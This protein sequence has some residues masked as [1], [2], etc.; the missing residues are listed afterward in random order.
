MKAQ[1]KINEKIKEV[2]DRLN[3]KPVLK[4]TNFQLSELIIP[5]GRKHV[6]KRIGVS[7][8]TL[9]VKDKT[10]K[11]EKHRHLYR[12]HKKVD[13]GMGEATIQDKI[14]DFE[15]SEVKEENSSGNEESSFPTEDTNAEN[16]K[17]EEATTEEHV[18]EE[19]TTEDDI[20]TI[21]ATDPTILEK[22]TTEE[23]TEVTIIDNESFQEEDY[24][25][26][27]NYYITSQED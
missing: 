10:H 7:L 3:L 18:I 16:A 4:V 14:F 22:A 17:I 27:L 9:G 8:K 20:M 19:S 5:L 12:H 11:G 23:T 24:D 25:L 1:N 21:P 13:D 2:F 26:G 15:D 6:D